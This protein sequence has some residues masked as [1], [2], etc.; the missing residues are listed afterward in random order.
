MKRRTLVFRVGDHWFLRN[1]RDLYETLTS[2][3]TT[4]DQPRGIMSIFPN[5]M[6]S[7][8]WFREKESFENL[9]CY[10]KDNQSK[11]AFHDTMEEDAELKVYLAGHCYAGSS[12]LFSLETNEALFFQLEVQTIAKRLHQT[13][14]DIGVK[15]TA[16]KPIKISLICCEAA[17][18]S[19]HYGRKDAFAT[20]LLEHL[21]A[22]GHQ[23]ILVKARELSVSAPIF[24]KKYTAGKKEHF[25]LDGNHN[26][27]HVEKTNDLRYICLNQIKKCHTNTRVREKQ[28]YL[29]HCIRQIEEL[30]YPT[31]QQQ[32]EALKQIISQALE[33]DAVKSFRY[34]TGYVMRF[35]GRQSNTE[36]VLKELREMLEKRT[37]VYTPLVENINTIPK[38]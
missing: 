16:A 37:E 12:D 26:I 3:Y 35:L 4:A 21:H 8:F 17:S 32:I 10:L 5:R 30:G 7:P 24:G 34:G 19:N 23:H 36:L 25:Y 18:G 29:E 13:F 1:V 22:L 20:Q 2:K 28:E 14:Q 11:K 9:A 6:S 38:F 27:Y 31:Q 15:P 33:Q